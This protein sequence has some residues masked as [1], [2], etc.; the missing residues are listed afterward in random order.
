MIRCGDK[1]CFWNSA[2]KDKRTCVCDNCVESFATDPNLYEACVVACNS[3]DRSKRPQ[4]SEDFM[5][6][7]IGGEVLWSRYHL[8]KCNYDPTQSVEAKTAKKS[9]ELINQ[10]GNNQTKIIGAIMAMIFLVIVLMLFKT[11]K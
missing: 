2:C 7:K 11:L 9:Q 5:C 1:K 4:S 10:Q 6:G 3:D 8:T